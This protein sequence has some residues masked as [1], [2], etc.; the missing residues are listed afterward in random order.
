M[1]NSCFCDVSSFSRFHS[2]CSNGLILASHVHDWC[3]SAWILT[4]ATVVFYVALV[5]A[6]FSC[7]IAH[8]TLPWNR[9]LP[10]WILM[11]MQASCR[12][13]GLS[14]D[15]ILALRRD[16]TP[17]PTSTFD[18]VKTFGLRRRRGCKAGRSKAIGRTCKQSFIES[19]VHSVRLCFPLPGRD[20]EY[21]HPLRLPV[22]HRIACDS[23]NDSSNSAEV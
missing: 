8:L 6:T 17:L 15:Q 23:F 22:I 19:A 7:L 13:S 10:I 11:S 16:W 9:R 4:V 5:E 1:D 18:I 14:R 21:C 3:V 12:S 20:C 2:D